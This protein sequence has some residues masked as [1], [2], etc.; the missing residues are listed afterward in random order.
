MGDCSL[1]RPVSCSTNAYGKSLPEGL[2]TLNN[3]S[4]FNS[5][6]F[7]DDQTALI[8]PATTLIPDNTNFV[9]SAY[10]VRST[11]QSITSQCI[12]MKNTG[13]D[14]YLA[15]NCASST[16]FNFSLPTTGTSAPF[17]VLNSSGIVLDLNSYDVNSKCVSFKYLGQQ[18]DGFTSSP[19]KFAAVLTSQAYTSTGNSCKHNFIIS[20]TC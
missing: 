1:R 9:A 7:S 10:G 5:V 17:G 11:C 15:L 4:I 16:I 12:N 8:A 3:A 6:A 19:F 2:R 20:R 18:A 14:A 13:P